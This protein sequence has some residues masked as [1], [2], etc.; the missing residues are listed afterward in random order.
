MDVRE[1]LKAMLQN[2]ASDLH[3]KV[4]VAPVYRIDGSLA[5]SEA[6]PLSREDMDRVLQD[7]LTEDQ[8]QEF[9]DH[10]ELDC[11]VGVRQLGRFRVN[12]GIQRGTPTITIR[13]IPI[14]IKSIHALNLPPVVGELALKPRGLILVTGITGS[15]KSTTLAAMVEH[16]NA[17]KR[18]KVVTIED[19]IEYLFRDSEAFITQRE[20]G[21]DTH[22]FEDGL[23]HVL[24]QDPDVVMIGEIRDVETMDIALKAANTGHLVLA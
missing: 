17:R 12:V 5:P 10:R 22:S 13:A 24:R 11:A 7:L 6:P 1:H 18:L 19:P 16:V 8:L 14:S 4:G 9:A 23:R 2:E 21:N 15:G 3:L 20:V